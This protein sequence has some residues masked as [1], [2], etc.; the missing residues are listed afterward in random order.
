MNFTIKR[1]FN[2]SK[3]SNSRTNNTEQAH[4]IRDKASAKSAASRI[5][6]CFGSHSSGKRRFGILSSRVK[7]STKTTSLQQRSAATT[8]ARE[9]VSTAPNLA[10]SSPVLGPSR[11]QVVD[12]VVKT[13][14][15]G[16]VKSSEIDD[17]FSRSGE[18]QHPL[19]QFGSASSLITKSIE[20][21]NLR[22]RLELTEK[23]AE[24]DKRMLVINEGVL[25]SKDEVEASCKEDSPIIS[26]IIRK[27]KLKGSV[28]SPI[29]GERKGERYS[30]TMSDQEPKKRIRWNEEV[31]VKKVA[32]IE[33]SFYG[34]TRPESYSEL[35]PEQ[36]SKLRK[37]EVRVDA[38][39]REQQADV[40]W[41]KKKIKKDEAFVKRE[42]R[43]LKEFVKK[44]QTDTETYQDVQEQKNRR[45]GILENRREILA[46]KQAIIAIQS[47]QYKKLKSNIFYG[48]VVYDQ[49][50]Q[51]YDEKKLEKAIKDQYKDLI[52]DELEREIKHDGALDQLKQ[53]LYRDHQEFKDK[54]PGEME[55]ANFESYQRGIYADNKMKLLYPE[56][57]IGGSVS[58]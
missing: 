17:F 15:S 51:S 4:G 57:I 7:P 5:F 52:S 25:V 45:V 58:E 56:H 53:K 33:Q 23:S 44:G 1:L 18:Q 6:S 10:S 24:I 27:E 3:V 29:K 11:Q 37:I 46:K 21:F 49:S 16:E 28:T 2:N 30:S 20:S 19:G 39:I 47:S 43:R 31:D 50:K 40:V 35:N 48:K 12:D 36:S 41:L 22:S 55:M 42:G 26:P 54:N 34:K 8:L 13:S 38:M 14:F 9:G 32:N